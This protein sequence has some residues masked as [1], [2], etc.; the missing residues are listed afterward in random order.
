MGEECKGVEIQPMSQEQL[1][2]GGK[3]GR[4]SVHCAPDRGGIHSL[5][6]VIDTA[7]L[8]RY[9]SVWPK[10]PFIFPIPDVPHFGYP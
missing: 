7:L 6:G 5:I 3:L 8:R 4:A 1:H 9:C 2:D 10:R